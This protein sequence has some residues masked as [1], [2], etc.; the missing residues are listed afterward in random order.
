MKI[1]VIVPFRN[2]E[3]YIAAAILSLRQQ[4]HTHFEAIL[5]DDGSADSSEKIVQDLIKNDTRF[6][7]IST[8]PSGVSN[9]RNLGLSLATGQYIMFLDSDDSYMPTCLEHV[10][11]VAAH[12]SPD[13][14]SFGFVNTETFARGNHKE[15]QIEQERPRST[16]EGFPPRE[17]HRIVASVWSKAFRRGFITTNQLKFSEKLVFGT[18]DLHFSIQAMIVANSVVELDF[19]LYEYQGE[20]EGSLSRNAIS[21]NLESILAIKLIL[22]DF[23]TAH[24]W[25]VQLEFLLARFVIRAFRTRPNFETLTNIARVSGGSLRTNDWVV[26]ILIRALISPGF[27]TQ[28]RGRRA[29]LH[30]KN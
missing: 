11:R 25:R 1:S 3:R 21:Q 23:G 18:E 13:I 30:N 16:S 9:A 27:W 22:D 17:L 15:L 24:R 19:P 6:I 10:S 26:L 5:V 20:V 28:V 8:P 7:L 12:S 2:S 4:S 29:E 14:I